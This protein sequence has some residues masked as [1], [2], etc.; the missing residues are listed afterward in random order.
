MNPDPSITNTVINNHSLA[1]VR[2][3]HQRTKHQ[4]TAY[5]QGPETLDWDAQPA[6]FRHFENTANIQLPN[7]NESLKEPALLAALERPFGELG[8]A[9]QPLPYTLSTLGALLQLALGI[10]AW[11]SYGPDRWAVRANPSS[12]NLHPIEAYVIVGGLQ[13][14]VDGVYH[15]CP[16]SHAL[17]CRAE[18]RFE[19]D[20]SPSLQ[21]GLSTVM[22]REAWKYGERAFRYCQLDTGHAIGSLSY[23]AQVLGWSL[24]E[25]TD[26][27]TDALAHLLGVDRSADFPASRQ[28]ETE[29]EEAVVLLG[30]SFNSQQPHMVKSAPPEQWHG[31]ASTIDAHP[32]YRWPIIDEVALASRYKANNS[33]LSTKLP[34]NIINASTKNNLI[35]AASVILGR[36]SAQRF[37]AN[38]VMPAQDFIAM[39]E[40]LLPKDTAPWNALTSA[41][42]I[43]LFL[44]VHRV[45][46]FKAG[47]YLLTRTPRL[48][49]QL[50]GLLKQNFEYEPVTN[51]PAHLNLQF[52]TPSP[53]SDLNRIAR[54]LHCHQ[55]IASNACFALGMLTEYNAVLVD[56]PSGYRSIHREA[57]F[58][59]QVLY[60]QAEMFG[61]RG[62]GIG[63]FFDDPIHELLGLTDETFQ[64]I[65][66]F[67]VGLPLDDTRIENVPTFSL[68]NT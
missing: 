39:L 13:G 55:D 66:H 41:P 15:Y 35:S 67:T 68:T 24:T 1:T 5:A 53:V 28:V 17:E 37:N 20:S 2:A 65:Y 58:I 34:T 29:R 61:L 64:T 50:D 18:L 3:Y 52:L 19:A 48:S 40:A 6:P 45:E 22:W 38:H 60:L 8:E 59:G 11:K 57:G 43:N 32:F 14:V 16:D 25:K 26:I 44:F 30:V 9:I 21:I 47:L 12:G 51:V 56:N 23:A 33:N 54:S 49:P 10:T 7:F 62:T 42:S 36:R 31:I 27:T 63:C 46:S 4:F